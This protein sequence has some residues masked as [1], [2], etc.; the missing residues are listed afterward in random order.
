MKNTKFLTIL[1]IG[2]IIASLWLN[3][4]AM[5]NWQ[6]QSQW[7]DKSWS[8]SQ[9]KHSW[10]SWYMISNI[11]LSELSEQEKL[12][13]AYQY[14]E[15]MVARDA[16]NYF[17]SLYWQETFKNIAE[18]EAEHMA[19]VK[20]LLDRYNL[21]TPTWYGELQDEFNTLKSEWEKGIK[22]ALEVWLK[23][24]MLDINDIKDTIKST[25]NEDIKI[26]FTNIWWASYNHMR[27]FA[28]WLANNNITTNIDYSEY[29]SNEQVNSKWTL[30]YLLSENLEK[31][32]I[33]LPKQANSEQ[34]KA[35]CNN[36]NKTDDNTIQWK[37]NW[38]WNWKNMNT[39]EKNKMQEMK[40]QYKE[41]I[42]KKYWK[43]LS[44]MSDEKLLQIDKKIDVAVD[45]LEKK[46]I[47]ETLK[48]KTMA[49]Y[50]ALKEY[51]NELIY[52]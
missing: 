30:K 45:N 4:Y 20:V 49:L 2:T 16:Y 39:A 48:Q 44:K 21:P 32:W 52:K 13:L 14:S 19:A 47:T 1:I 10:N 34:I 6:W 18:S 22:E 31:E 26:V 42:D 11:P 28:K 37:K 35:N 36:L 8:T 3:T 15:E 24:E 9:T 33:I 40:N 23:I 29:L 38:N 7:Q 25:D 51:I 5:G 41:Q 43:S 12:D 46:S 17:Y 27:G 50:I